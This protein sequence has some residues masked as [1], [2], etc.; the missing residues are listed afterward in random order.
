MEIGIAASYIAK[1]RLGGTEAISGV[2]FAIVDESDGNGPRI[3]HWDEEKLGPQPTATELQVASLEAVQAAK[4]A[5]LRDAADAWYRQNVRAFEGAVVI[6]KIDRG[7][8]LNAEETAIRDAMTANYTKLKD[9]IAQ[10]RAA[11]SL[12]ELEAVSWET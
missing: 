10:V 2:D 1:E 3:A 9:L 7:L 6:H 12:A 5:E 8:A 4:E 11:Q